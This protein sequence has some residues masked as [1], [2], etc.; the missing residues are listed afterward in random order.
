MSC[1]SN[2]SLLVLISKTPIV[3]SNIGVRVRVHDIKQVNL[4]V[5]DMLNPY[6]LFVLRLS[7]HVVEN[8]DA[9]GNISDSSSSSDS[10]SSDSSDSS[11]NEMDTS[12]PGKFIVPVYVS[13][14]IL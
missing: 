3:V 14:C 6:W 8:D 12:Q 1:K 13:T 4:F 7:H 9:I 11:D 10:D 5:C 2:T